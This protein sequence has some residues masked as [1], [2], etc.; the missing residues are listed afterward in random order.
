MQTKRFKITGD[1]QHDDAVYAEAAALIRAGELVAFPTETVYG[2]GANALDGEAVK[3]IYIAK[4]R[5][6][7]N[8]LITHVSSRDML[9]TLVRSYPK[10]FEAL[11]AK[12]MPGPL[13]FLLPK[14]DIVPDEVS[15]GL[16]ATTVR[17]PKHPVALKLIETAGVPIAAPSAN[18]SGRTS[19]TTAAHVLED[20]DGRIAAVIDGGTCEVGVESTVIDIMQEPPLILRPGGVTKEEIEAV[21]G[22]PV[23]VFK[24]SAEGTAEKGLPSPGM[25]LRHYAP[26]AKLINTGDTAEQLFAE[27]S[28]QVA[29]GHKVGILL[30]SDW[31]LPAKQKGSAKLVVYDYGS[32]ADWQTMAQRVFD[33]LRMLDKQGV[34][35]IIGPLPPEQ[36]LGLALRD[37]LMRAAK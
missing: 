19:P 34:N 8:P 1:K 33:G 12:F 22:R 23:N 31:V 21:L 7:W 20:L 10:D 36:G 17:M 32:W 37:R 26:N 14:T 15:A 16:D 27:L 3:K 29:A 18:R 25:L 13:T 4:G 6:S 30:P 11:A 24:K 28:A 5:P 9:N 2:L 35:V